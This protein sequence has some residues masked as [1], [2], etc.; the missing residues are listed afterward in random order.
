MYD[1]ECRLDRN[2]RFTVFASVFAYAPPE[3]ALATS[4]RSI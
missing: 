4:R 1:I 3:R 2:G